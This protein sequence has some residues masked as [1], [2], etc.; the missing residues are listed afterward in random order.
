VTYGSAY[1][2]LPTPT[3]TGYTFSGWYTG[4]NGSGTQVTASTTV[5]ATADHALYAKWTASSYTVTF[6]AQGG[7]VSP[8]NAAVMYG[9]AYGTQPTPTRTG[10]TFGGWY[11]GA[12]GSGFLVTASTTLATASNHTLY[13]KWTANTYTARTTATAARR[14]DTELRPYVRRRRWLSVN[15]YI[16]TGYTFMGWATSSG[17]SVAYGNGQSVVNLASTQGA[18]VTLY[19][20]WTGNPYTVFFDAQG[21]TVGAISKAVTYGSAYGTLPT[22]TKAELYFGG[23]WT[24]PDG[25]GTRVKASTAVAAAS[26]HTLYAKWIDSYI[27]PP[28]TTRRWRRRARTTGISTPRAPSKRGRCRLCRV[29]CRWRSRPSA[30]KLTAKATLQTGTVSFSGKTWGGQTTT[31]RYMPF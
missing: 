18:T 5:T 23:W 15:G 19:A 22:P 24:G 21:G 7:T 4:A 3:R 12:N 28:R 2:V 1:G 17:G 25:S 31:G 16:R 20:K 8:A 26:D 11:T 30:G 6:D 27:E 14:L 9:T 13:A 10:Y 29:P